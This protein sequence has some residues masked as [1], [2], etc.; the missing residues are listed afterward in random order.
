MKNNYIYFRIL[1]HLL[2]AFVFLAELLKPNLPVYIYDFLV[3]NKDL[4]FG[5]YYIYLSYE[6]YSKIEIQD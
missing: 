5:F 2:I 4:I 3:K 6:L 1:I